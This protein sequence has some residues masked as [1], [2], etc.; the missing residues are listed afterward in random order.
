MTGRVGL[1]RL[2]KRKKSAPLGYSLY[3]APGIIMTQGHGSYTLSLPLR[4]HQDFKR[5]LVDMQ[6]GKTGGGDLADSLI[7]AQY[8]WRF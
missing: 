1:F 6:L 4:V 3:L 7:L 8:S 5:S 2:E